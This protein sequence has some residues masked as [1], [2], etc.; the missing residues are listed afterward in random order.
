MKRTI[1]VLLAAVLL[2]S[3][4]ACGGK[5][6]ETPQ[7]EES[8]AP[9]QTTAPAQTAAVN[10]GGLYVGLD[11]D[12]YYRQYDAADVETSGMFGRFEAVPG[13]EK[14][15]MVRHADG[16]TEALFTDAGAGP[17]VLLDRT[18]YL[19]TSEYA[20][21]K[22]YCVDLA[23]E[24]RTELL[25]GRILAV[26]EQNGRLICQN[27]TNIVSLDCA[28]NG[29][30]CQS[31]TLATN[32]TYAGL[33]DGRVYYS[34][35]PTDGAGARKGALVFR[36]VATDGS[37]VRTLAQTEPDLYGMESDT[38]AT[39]VC[40]QVVGDNVYFNYGA[41]AGTAQVFQGG[42]VLRVGT[43]GTG[44]MKV[45]DT[46]QEDFYVSR[47][48]GADYLYYASG[49]VGGS[50]ADV[51]CRNVA[52]GAEE[53]AAFA[54]PIGVPYVDSRTAE[55]S[56][57]SDETGTPTTL[58]TAQDL[59]GYDQKYGCGEETLYLVDQVNVVGN[60]VFFRILRGTHD[61]ANDIG[62]RYIYSLTGAAVYCRDL[63]TGAVTQVFAY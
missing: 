40:V 52:T 25:D 48:N 38:D 11:G 47:R 17:I 53:P 42:R 14:Q 33:A 3:L 1:S 63:T 62:W 60:L 59:A 32:V 30:D 44:L 24:H 58:F 6:A 2:L 61:A 36:S 15:M 28:G 50:D 7:P 10:N 4:C 51:V 12:V 13:T 57:Y 56:I 45:A 27:G 46:T 41:Y 16:S 31:R 43:D 39:V 21:G 23:G 26:D 5:P 55:G 9:E 37:D 35:A 18:F 22:V 29:A 20:D 8:A 34:S 49:E 54:A 19:Q